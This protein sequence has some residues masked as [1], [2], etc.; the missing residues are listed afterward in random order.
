MLVALTGFSSTATAVAHNVLDAPPGGI[1][2]TTSHENTQP[3]RSWIWR[4]VTPAHALAQ[5]ATHFALYPPA[6][7]ATADLLSPETAQVWNDA[8]MP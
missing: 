4:D 6:L 8:L 2:V 5:Q 7:L 1:T 3:P